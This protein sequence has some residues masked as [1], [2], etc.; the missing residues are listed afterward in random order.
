MMSSIPSPSSAVIL[1]TFATLVA[2][3]VNGQCMFPCGEVKRDANDNGG[4]QAKE[5]GISSSST[6]TR[7]GEGRVGG[8]GGGGCM[9]GE[10]DL[11]PIGAAELNI[12]EQNLQGNTSLFTFVINLC[13]PINQ[14]PGGATACSGGAGYVSQY[15]VTSCVT[16][17]ETILGGSAGYNIAQLTYGQSRESNHPG[18]TA[19]VFLSCGNTVALTPTATATMSEGANA[20]LVTVNLYF[21]SSQICSSGPAP[22]TTVA[23][24]TPTPLTPPNHHFVTVLQD[25]ATAVASIVVFSGNGT[26]VATSPVQWTF[27][28][29]HVEVSVDSNTQQIYVITFPAATNNNAT[30][31]VLPFDLSTV[32]TFVTTNGLKYFDLQFSPLQDVFY[33]ITVSG[34]YGRVLSRFTSFTGPNGVEYTPISALPY[35]WYVNASTFDPQTSRYF[36]LLNEFPG[37]PNASHYQ[38]LAVGMYGTINASGTMFLDLAVNVSTNMEPNTTLQVRFIAWSSPTA[39]LF[40]YAD[41]V[42]VSIDL[43]TGSITPLVWFVFGTIAETFFASDTRPE[44]TAF[45][46]SSYGGTRMMAKF[47]VSDPNNIIIESYDPISTNLRVAASARLF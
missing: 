43:N 29:P 27:S 23:P 34:Q 39:T 9:I 22:P 33:G 10:F 40:G 18:W 35:M 5:N 28:F 20:S 21:S 37:T 32:E 16:A 19:N 8:N 24:T 12:E 42:I 2:V 11:S 6:A 7:V 25:N 45:F 30:L 3:T 17:W 26:V 14:P 4:A 44:L 15:S 36:G 47:D 13:G 31:F 46:V 1:L 38:Q 41:N